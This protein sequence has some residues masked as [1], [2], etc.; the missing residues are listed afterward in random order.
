MIFFNDLIYSN[1]VLEKTGDM[2]EMLE[3]SGEAQ[4]HIFSS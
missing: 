1:Q 4:L 3:F 2:S